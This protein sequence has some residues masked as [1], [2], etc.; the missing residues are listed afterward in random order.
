[1]KLG[2]IDNE[3]FPIVYH[4][5]CT[6]L[7]LP[8]L[9]EVNI[10]LVP[11]E[12]LQPG[13]GLFQLGALLLQMG[14]DALSLAE[15]LPLL[16]LQQLCHPPLGLLHCSLQEAELLLHDSTDPCHRALEGGRPTVDW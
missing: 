1:M 11:A 6:L 16:R 8:H 12:S 14:L 3:L 15:R 7:S 4:M 2:D 5:E 13:R 9:Q 10:N